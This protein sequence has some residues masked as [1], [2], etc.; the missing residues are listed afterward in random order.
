MRALLDDHVINDFFF[1]IDES[2]SMRT[3]TQT[4][5]RVFDG[6]IADLAKQA[7]EFGQETRVSIYAFNSAGTERCIVW[8]R[9][10]AGIPS[11]AGRYQPTGY[12]AA[13]DCTH[14]AL[15]DLTLIPQKYGDR[16]VGIWL[17]TDGQENDSRRSVAELRRRFEQ[18][19]DNIAIGAYV[20][21][22]RGKAFARDK[23]G[24]PED[25]IKLWNPTGHNAVEQLGREMAGDARSFMQAR[26]TAQRSGVRF[27]GRSLFGLADFSAADV[28]SQLTP[29]TSGSYYTVNVTERSRIDAY[30]GLGKGFY[31][32]VKTETIQGYKQVAVQLSDGKVYGGP[33]ARQLIGLPDHEI[34]VNPRGS[35]YSDRKIFVQSTAPNRVLPAGTTLLVMR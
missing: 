29:L 19:A 12:T 7:K 18:R 14:L 8:D 9:D 17:L 31:E 30:A 6:L 5:V 22:Q 26:A 28:Q 23:C 11:I 13:V 35:Q 32:L 2:S 34:K 1:L 4:V 25:A 33:A 21:D 3:H 24:Y 15:D 27:T 10:V 20:P 16:A